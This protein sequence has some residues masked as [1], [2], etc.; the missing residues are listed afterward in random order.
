MV[1]GGNDYP[2]NVLVERMKIEEGMYLEAYLCPNNVW[3]IGCGHTE[4][5]TSG[6]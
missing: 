3:T 6:M 1:N 5:V 4:G 2:M